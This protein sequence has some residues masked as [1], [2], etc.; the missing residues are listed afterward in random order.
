MTTT[1]LDRTAPTDVPVLDILA[2][3][4]SPRA[5]DETAT[6]DEGALAR[7]L[8]AARWSPSAYNSQPW[9]FI[10]ARRGSEAFAGLSAALVEFNAA[11]ATR[12]GVLIAAIAE[13]E[14]E[15]GRANVTA[16]Y[17]LGQA[18][19]HLSVQAHH[20]GL[21]VHQMTGFDP[22]VVSERFSLADR[23]R[24]F[25]L[26]ALGEAGD[27]EILPDAMRERELAP[28]ERRA[29]AETVLVND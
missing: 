2:A 27:P 10:V 16:Q 26:L 19:A 20:D 22:A 25:T 8:E 24:P 29:L 18:V 4:W 17:D 14:N 7:A 3:R 9:R 23:F 28:R 5:Y 21:F 11:W 1:T 15:A 13:T 6:V 12:A